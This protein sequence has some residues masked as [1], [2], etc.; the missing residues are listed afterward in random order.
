M[1]SRH[2]SATFFTVMTGSV[3]P[4]SHTSTLSRTMRNTSASSRPIWRARLACSGG[5]RETITEM[6][7]TLSMPSTISS[8]VNVNSAAQASGLVSNSIML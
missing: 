4:I 8:A 3:R 1:M 2:D 7:M 5:M 6:K